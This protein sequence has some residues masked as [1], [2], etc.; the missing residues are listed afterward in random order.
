[1][2]KN[3]K[4]EKSEK[5]AK[6]EKPEGTK[7]RKQRVVGTLAERWVEKAD[8]VFSLAADIADKAAKRGAPAEVVESAKALVPLI[9]SW[10]EK[11]I[12]LKEI[13]WEPAGKPAAKTALVEGDSISFVDDPD[14]I[15]AYSYI[16]GVV[17]KTADLIV[18]GIAQGVG[19][20]VKI[21][22]KD[23]NGRGYGWVPRGHLK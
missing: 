8:K 2:S 5:P 23:R 7:T 16:E 10:R 12:G 19:K 18:G 11:F 21:L 13:K 4:S 6:A 9:E 1:M 20:T 3:H 14:V 17:E 22:V 15:A